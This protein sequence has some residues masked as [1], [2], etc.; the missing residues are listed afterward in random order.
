MTGRKDDHFKIMNNTEIKEQ[1]LDDAIQAIV[2]M[3][4]ILCDQSTKVSDENV[5]RIK[6]VKKV[7]AGILNPMD[8]VK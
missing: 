5:T 1:I 7:V 3:A 4:N 8:K 6:Y 2:V